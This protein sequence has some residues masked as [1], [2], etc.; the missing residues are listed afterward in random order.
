MITQF[1]DAYMRHLA[2]MVHVKLTIQVAYAVKCYFEKQYVIF[3]KYMNPRVL[4]KEIK[5]LI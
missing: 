4:G 1:A 2:L 3:T 5:K